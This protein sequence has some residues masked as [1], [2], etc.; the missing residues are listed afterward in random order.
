MVI[1]WWFHRIFMGISCEPGHDS[2]HT[3]IRVRPTSCQ[4]VSYPIC[5]PWCWNMHTNI[6]PCP[7]SPS[8]VGFYIP[9]PWF[10]S[11][12]GSMWSF[13]SSQRFSQW[14]VPGPVPL[15]V[16]G[17][18]FSSNL[19]DV[20]EQNSE[21]STR[22]RSFSHWTFHFWLVVDLP[23]WKIW[24]SMGRIIPYIMENKKCLKA[25]TSYDI[26]FIMVIYKSLLN[27]IKSLFV[28]GSKPPTR[29][30]DSHTEWAN[31][32]CCTEWFR[33][34]GEFHGEKGSSHISSIDTDEDISDISI[35]QNEIQLDQHLENHAHITIEGFIWEFNGWVYGNI[36]TGKPPYDLHRKIDGFRHWITANFE[37]YMTGDCLAPSSTK[38]DMTGYMWYI[39]YSLHIHYI[40]ITY[41]WHIHCISPQGID[42]QI[43]KSHRTAAQGT[44][45][46]EDSHRRWLWCDPD[47]KKHSDCQVVTGFPLG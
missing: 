12:Y 7:K 35:Q 18:D 15:Q 24:K 37:N 30:G 27:P 17:M 29:L 46:C 40:F 38:L 3:W 32:W 23:L 1:S 28:A 47:R 20:E 2:E 9:A 4:M 44:L 42:R 16:M 5:E 22:N 25:P 21:F 39:T 26:P 45:R 11:G 34:L 10:A 14:L 31:V 13:G 33:C 19:S 41:S 8:F 43:A 36:L 6:C